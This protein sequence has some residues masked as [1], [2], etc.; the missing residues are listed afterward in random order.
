MGK[1]A[2]KGRDGARKGLGK[3]K[4]SSNGGRKEMSK[5]GREQEKN[6]NNKTRKGGGGGWGE[7]G[8]RQTDT[9][10]LF[11]VLYKD[12]TLTTISK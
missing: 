3:R 10:V 6:E 2:Q 11:G 12:S 4:V 5:R 7:T 8:D 1:C 9:H